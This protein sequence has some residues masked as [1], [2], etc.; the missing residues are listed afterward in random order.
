M[1]GHRSELA[2][3]G[4]PI[5][6]YGYYTTD[7]NAR[8]S[9]VETSWLNIPPLFKADLVVWLSDAQGLGHRLAAGRHENEEELFGFGAVGVVDHHAAGEA[10]LDGLRCHD[11]DLTGIFR[12][13]L[14]NGLGT[15]ALKI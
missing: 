13:E 8:P 15:A 4:I 11:L 14:E 9:M 3:P 1:T 12:I 10:G 2:P 5:N 6:I 7:L